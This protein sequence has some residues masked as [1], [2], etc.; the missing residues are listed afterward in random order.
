M[1]W[2]R[3]AAV[4]PGGGLGGKSASEGARDGDEHF[5]A[6]IAGGKSVAGE[7]G[8]Q[9]DCPAAD[10]LRGVDADIP[11]KVDGERGEVKVRMMPKL[12]GI[13]LEFGP[14]PLVNR[15]DTP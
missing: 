1:E 6:G 14:L 13:F 3:G 4:S 9:G 8:G 11:G 15:H 7:S 5:P 12:I 10:H 2:K